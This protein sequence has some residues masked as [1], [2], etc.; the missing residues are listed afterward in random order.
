MTE[1]YVGLCN[2]LQRLWR[3]ARVGPFLVVGWSSSP[4]ADMPH[5]PPSITWT[6]GR[7]LAGLLWA[8]RAKRRLRLPARRE[9]GRGLPGYLAYLVTVLPFRI[10]LR[11]RVT[12]T[13]G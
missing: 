9:A 7:S 13:G 3:T 12:M 6:P 11:T 1:G 4:A 10:R 8:S 5:R 2:T